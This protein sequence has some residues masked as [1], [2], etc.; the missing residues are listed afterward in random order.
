MNTNPVEETFCLLCQQPQ[1]PEG[2]TNHGRFYCKTCDK[3]WILE[4][5]KIPRAAK[6]VLS[7]EEKTEF[8]LDCLSL[9][10]SS[11]GLE[12]LLFR[13]TELIKDRLKREKLAIFIANLELGDIR[14]AFYS[15]NQKSLQRAI[16]RIHI[17]YDLSFGVLVESM[18]KRET[19]FYTLSEQ[20]HP[21]YKFYSELTGTKAQ[22][23]I[24]IL[25]ANTAVGMLAVDYEDDDYSQ[26]L[27]DQD[28]LQLVVG[29]FAVSLRNSLLY[30]KSQNQSKNF[31]SLHTAALTL[32]KLYLDN[33]HE[34]IRMILLT[35]SG[36]VESNVAC[37][38][39]KPKTTMTVKVFKI[40]RDL[41]NFQIDTETSMINVSSLFHL[42]HAKE[43]LTIDPKEYPL[44]YTL[45][46]IGR[47]IVILPVT[48]ENGTD[49][50]FVL[51]KPDSRFPQDEIEALNAFVSLARI[52]ME[53][54]TLY[55]NLS[56]KERLE[57]EI[58]IAKEIQATL[59]PRKIPET[60]YLMF[61]GFMMPAR[62][63]GG[64]YYDYILAPNNKE[65]FL[66]I[67]DVSGKGVAAGLVMATVRTI[68]HSLVRVKDS[69]WEIISD[70]NN[71]LHSSYK[72]ALTPRFMSLI[73]LRWS[74]E[75]N[76]IVVSG[77]GHG[78]FYIHRASENKLD[79]IETGGVI[80]G[81]TNDISNFKNEASITMKPNDTI[82]MFTDGV[83]EAYN[84]QEEQFGEV[85][86]KEKFL[87][88]IKDDPKLILENIYAAI[89][90]F[91]KDKEQH[92]DITMVAI[93][94]L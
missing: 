58:E 22:L 11:M 4:K 53:N 14:L 63:I 16:K 52:T 25:Y 30:S 79:E 33:H 34:M 24:P 91:M 65:L 20:S 38:I 2:I 83:T 71:Y 54:A 1:V 57:K 48:L 67:G 49:C 12:D 78:S 41:D 10:N 76:K 13:F 32:S 21:F 51:A 3:E 44:F 69:P 88:S 60:K 23:V 9:F 84:E 89:K 56:K 43:T 39:E 40:Q 8:L 5:R 64:D 45:G 59:L 42:L 6:T 46:V 80:L 92:D 47:E 70:I 50:I 74:L 17:D 29:Q 87:S 72:D 62:G 15:A 18:A 19:K 77:A 35:L 27:E 55:E 94:K 73:L 93:R 31:Q 81:I 75:T 61:G 90:V 37:L 66:C 28:I 85:A 26:H 7:S 86:L 68:L 82:L 36:I